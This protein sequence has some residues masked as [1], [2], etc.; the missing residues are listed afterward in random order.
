[1]GQG[2]RQDKV[3]PKQGATATGEIKD[4][5]PNEI[6]IEVRGADQKYPTNEISR[7]QFDGEPSSFGRIKEW[8]GQGQLDQ[9]LEETKRIDPASLK[10]D[11]IRNEFAFYKAYGEGLLAL[12][13]KGALDKPIADLKAYIRKEAK[14][15]HYYDVCELLG[16]LT[17]EGGKPLEAV[18]YFNL[19]TKAPFPSTVLQAKYLLAKANLAASKIPEARRLSSEVLAA[20]A[21]DQQV[22]SIQRLTTVL[23]ARCDVA[24]SK[25]DEGLQ[26]LAKLIKENEST[27]HE[28]FAAI[29]NAQGEAFAKNNQWEAAVLAY[30]HVDLLFFDQPTHHGEALAQLSQLWSKVGE[31]Q[32]GTEAKSR[33]VATYPSSK[34]AKP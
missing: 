30:L 19:M 34:W 7:V 21:N 24:E 27:D 8:V 13:G 22:A 18:P 9:A 31:S 5:S 4:I 17:I 15:Y 10:T 26:R 3:Y 14:S 11:A 25:V 33:L 32:R 16:K 20:G 2:Q 6:T 12:R 23:A 29:Y 1:M 28:L